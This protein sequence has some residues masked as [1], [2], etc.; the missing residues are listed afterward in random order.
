MKASASTYEAAIT[1]LAQ[2]VHARNLEIARLR[3]EL[4][5]R[6]QAHAELEAKYIALLES[7]VAKQGKVVS[8]VCRN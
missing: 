5:S 7:I 3:E 4:I 8:D 2:Q 1:A 6:I